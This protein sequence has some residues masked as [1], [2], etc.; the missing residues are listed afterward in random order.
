M[1]T[2]EF[3]MFS[4]HFE[5]PCS[6][7]RSAFARKLLAFI[8]VRTE[9]DWLLCSELPVVTGITIDSMCPYSE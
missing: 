3:F 9:G 1:T 4:L 7:W 8:F 6:S 2:D 5:G